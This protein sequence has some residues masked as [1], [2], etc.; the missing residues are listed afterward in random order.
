MQKKNRKKQLYLPT[1]AF[2]IDADQFRVI[3]NAIMLLKDSFVISAII[4]V[5]LVQYQAIILIFALSM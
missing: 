3:W 5:H 2:R 4:S 1:L